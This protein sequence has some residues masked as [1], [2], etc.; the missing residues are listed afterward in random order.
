[1]KNELSDR[2]NVDLV[3]SSPVD[4]L[5]PPRPS[6]LPRVLLRCRLLLF[7]FLLLFRSF[8]LRRSKKTHITRK[9]T[10]K[11][12]T[13]YQALAACFAPGAARAARLT[14][15]AD[16]LRGTPQEA[17]AL[18]LAVETIKE[19]KKKTKEG[20]ERKKRERRQKRERM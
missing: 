17:E 5:F 18:R 19:V 8:K 15:A 12:N 16:K 14:F 20:V 9:R 1:M 13:H 6:S 10:Q 4:L 2:S 7:F 11:N 3:V